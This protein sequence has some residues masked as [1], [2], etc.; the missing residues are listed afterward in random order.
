MSARTR[1][2]LIS[3]LLVASLVV[4]VAMS[5]DS[6][7]RQLLVR[8]QGAL[9]G[10]GIAFYGVEI[11]GRDVML[12]GFVESQEQADR[13]E[14]LVGAIPGVRAVGNELVI[15]RVMEPTL[16]VPEGAT[17]GLRS[18]SLRLQRLG[19]RLVLSGTFPDDGSA[20]RL[21]RAAQERYG[22]ANVINSLRTSTAT[23][24]ADWTDTGPALL[25]VLDAVDDNGRVA[26]RGS[27][28]HLFGQVRSRELR[29]ELEQ[30]AQNIAAGLTWRFDLLT[31]DGATGGGAP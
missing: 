1:L 26:I 21:I 3:A 19:D 11:D 10:A 4:C 27:T 14:R 9:A 18:P 24:R 25:E 23:G 17:A 20:A 7:Q 16:A 22:A 5:V 31:R 29:G 15:E 12:R 8:S 6:I 30:A 28:A 13:I 2:G